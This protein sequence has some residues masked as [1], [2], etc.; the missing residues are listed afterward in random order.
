MTAPLSMQTSTVG[1]GLAEPKQ[2]AGRPGRALSLFMSRTVRHRFGDISIVGSRSCSGGELVLLHNARVAPRDESRRRR[3][4]RDEILLSR[5]FENRPE[6]L[7]PIRH[8]RQTG[9]GGELQ[10]DE[11]AGQR[12]RPPARGFTRTLRSLAVIDDGRFVG[13]VPGR[14]VCR[15]ARVQ[16]PEQARGCLYGDCC[17]ARQSRRLVARRDVSAAAVPR[18][19]LS[20]RGW[21]HP[22]LRG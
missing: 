6:L 22:D 1:A 21:T 4:S 16:G 2:S 14:V 12:W 7:I 19:S 20:P 18:R 15:G 13:R 17:F 5:G 11:S 3:G 10:P 9:V 8:P